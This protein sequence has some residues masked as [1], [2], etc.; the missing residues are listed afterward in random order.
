M[1]SPE[2]FLSLCL[3]ITVKVRVKSSSSTHDL[4]GEIFPLISN[5]C[6]ESLTVCVY[7]CAVIT[8]VCKGNTEKVL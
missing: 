6:N 8:C 5:L 2:L 4:V 1:S 7:D 3:C